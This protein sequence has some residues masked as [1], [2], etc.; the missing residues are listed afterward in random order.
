MNNEPICAAIAHEM[1]KIEQM[2]E[3]FEEQLVA[4]YHRERPNVR[5]IVEHRA[6]YMGQHDT[7][8]VLKALLERSET[9]TEASET[10]GSGS[11]AFTDGRELEMRLST[12][13]Q[14]RLKP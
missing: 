10:N 2:L 4:E 11:G 7:L 13:R 3:A 14:R 1:L 6:Y 8:S 5:R 9:P 12:L